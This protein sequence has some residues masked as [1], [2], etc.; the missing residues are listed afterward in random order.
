MIHLP[1]RSICCYQDIRIRC[2]LAGGTMHLARMFIAH[3]PAPAISRHLELRTFAATA[4]RSEGQRAYYAQFCVL[5][6][7]VLGREDKWSVGVRT[8]FYLN[9][10]S[11]LLQVS[12]KPG[13]VT[14]HHPSY[15]CTLWLGTRVDTCI[16][17]CAT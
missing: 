9:F 15:N 3:C 2:S 11:K 17:V 1:A 12:T 10:L 7:A 13:L 4:P 14:P 6:A 5:G 8:T 16:H